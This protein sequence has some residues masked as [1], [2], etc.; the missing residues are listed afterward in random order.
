MNHILV[1]GG[2]KAGVA[3][4]QEVLEAGKSVVILEHRA[5]QAEEI[6]P[7]LAGAS[8]LI[9]SGTNIDDLDAAGIRN[10]AMFVACTGSD[11]TNLVAASLAKHE[12]H[13]SLV[14]ARLVDRRNAWLYRPELGVDRVLDEASV[15]VEPIRV[16]LA[17]SG[18]VESE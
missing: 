5:E 3:I 15:F 17:A 9:G 13:V 7:R 2:G 10:C 18:G 4:S 1:V 14:V 8:V 16:L 6:R 11:E 12:F